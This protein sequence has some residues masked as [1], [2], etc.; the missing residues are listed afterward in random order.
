VRIALGLEYDGS[1]FSGFQ[2][3]PNLRTVQTTLETALSQI[4]D[5]SIYVFCAGRTDTGVHAVNQVIHFDTSTTRDKHTWIVGTNSLL[6]RDIVVKWI[7]IVDEQFHARF[8]ALNRSYR[9]IIF[10]RET[11]ISMFRNYVTHWPFPLD[12]DQMQAASG[13]LLGKHDFESFRGADCQAKTTVRCVENVSVQREDHFV[14][15]DIT[16]NAF[17]YRM[18]RNIVGVLLKIGMHQKP[19]EWMEEVMA[20]RTRKNDFMT[21]PPEGL[22]LTDILYP[23]RFQ[24]PI[25]MV[26]GS[27]VFNQLHKLA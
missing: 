6:P 2:V 20:M 22:Y 19:P 12:S 10:N 15:I 4:A 26:S 7:R 8:S 24:L 5:E 13:Y 18:V 16:A 3:Q 23:S 21:T 9:Y 17:L 1:C 25:N 11:R 14:V 27:L